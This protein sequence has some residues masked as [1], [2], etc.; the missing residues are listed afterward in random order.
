MRAA[1]DGFA[2]HLL[3]EPI[4][5]LTT[6]PLFDR[7]ALEGKAT[8]VGDAPHYFSV[9]SAQASAAR[10]RGCGRYRQQFTPSRR[11]PEVRDRGVRHGRWCVQLRLRY[12]APAD[13]NRR[14]GSGVPQ[15]D[16]LPCALDTFKT[17]PEADAMR[18]VLE[19]AT[20]ITVRE[21]RFDSTLWRSL[22]FLLIKSGS[23]PTWRFCWNPRR[24]IAL[25][26]SGAGWD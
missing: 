3:G 14:D 9:G 5:I 24:Q 18:S 10:D 11:G 22:E 21:G 16:D 20:L 8:V 6:D 19:R 12:V 2:R 25:P 23:R 15:A 4:T 17:K 1:I 13:R 26:D 7:L